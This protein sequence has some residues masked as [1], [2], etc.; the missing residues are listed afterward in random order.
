MTLVRKTSDESVT[1]STN[2]QSDDQL[3]L[4]IG[5]NET[6][7]FEYFL[8][9]SS[10]ST[11]RDIKYT[12]SMRNAG[13]TADVS[14]TS[15]AWTSNVQNGA[16]ISQITSNSATATAAVDDSI[17]FIR[18]RGVVTSNGAGTLRLRWAQNSSGSQAT[19]VQANSFLKA[20][21]F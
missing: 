4:A 21:K 11:A 7:E 12:L 19:V 16:D 18:I 17:N 15:I 10:S 5:A 2:V 20:G 8:I 14:V 9:A 13:D 1:N 3:S 6:W